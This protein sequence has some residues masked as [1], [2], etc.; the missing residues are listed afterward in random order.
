MEAAKGT[1]EKIF[2]NKAGYYNTNIDGNWYGTGLKQEPPFNEG[3]Y[4][5]FTFTRKGQFMNMDPTSVQVKKGSVQQGSEVSSFAKK[6]AASNSR[7]DYWNK[8]EER[9]ENVQA[10]INWQSSRNAAISVVSAMVQSEVVSLPAAKG[11]KYDAFMSLVD[12]V[13]TRYFHDTD[14]VFNNR[15]PPMGEVAEEYEEHS[16]EE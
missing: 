3:D 2:R 12:E 10:S 16:E 7:D 6:G 9:D 5:E 14:Y 15:T 13:T 11:K 4:L 8:K 1:V